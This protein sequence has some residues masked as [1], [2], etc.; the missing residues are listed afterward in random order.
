MADDEHLRDKVDEC[1]PIFPR[2]IISNLYAVIGMSHCTG[3][4][5]RDCCFRLFDHELDDFELKVLE[6]MLNDPGG[7]EPGDRE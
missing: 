5:H 2:A 4:T 1:E 3:L 6:K 7:W